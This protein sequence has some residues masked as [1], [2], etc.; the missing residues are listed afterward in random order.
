MSRRVYGWDQNPVVDH[1]A[2]RCSNTSAKMAVVDGLAL[3]VMDGEGREGIQLLEPTPIER[4]LQAI[5]AGGQRVTA[6]AILLFIKTHCDGANLHYE[7]PMAGDK[8][9]RRYGLFWRDKRLR[10]HVIRVSHRNLFATQAALKS[11]GL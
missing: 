4:E 2:Y 11:A 8:G 9:M 1:Y 10:S 3:E 5:S 7:I 6:S